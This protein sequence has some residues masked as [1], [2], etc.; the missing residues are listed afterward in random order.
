MVG[1]QDVGV[2]RKSIALP[3]VFDSIQIGKPI[4]IVAKDLLPLIAT[5]NDV[6]KG[7]FEFDP[8]FPGHAGEH[9]PLDTN[10]SILRSDPLHNRCCQNM[11]LMS[12]LM[13]VGVSMHYRR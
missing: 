7:P 4:P 10:K 5:D 8:W 9:N 1:H 13:A 2:N 11:T 3:V 6:V 12:V